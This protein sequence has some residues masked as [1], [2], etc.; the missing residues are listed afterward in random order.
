MEETCFNQDPYEQRYHHVSLRVFHLYPCLGRSV[1]HFLERW[2][3]E[4]ANNQ[5][6]LHQ[7]VLPIC[8]PVGLPLEVNPSAFFWKKKGYNYET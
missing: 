7:V 6:D 8:A 4:L 3:Q 2:G 5:Q 1:G